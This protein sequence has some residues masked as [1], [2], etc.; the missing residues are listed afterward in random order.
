MRLDPALDELLSQQAQVQLVKGGFG[1]TEGI[2]WVQRGKTGYLVFSDIPANVVNKMTPDGQV[3]VLVKESGYQ[4]PWNGYT[5]MMIGGIFT[6]GLQPGDPNYRQVV[7]VGS[8]GLTFD[9]QGRL[10]LCAYSTRAVQRIEKNGKRV[11]IADRYQGKRFNGPND[12]AV[13][14]DGTIYFSDTYGGMRGRAND[15]SKEIN[16][17]SFYMVRND[18]TSI[19]IQANPDELSGANGLA[20]SPDEKYLYV[21][22]GDKSVWRYEVQADDT[23]AN[24]RQIADL[25]GEQGPGI[26]DGMKVDSKGNL[27]QSGP[28]GI[29]ILSPEG[30]RLGMIRT[31]EVVGNLTFGDP[32]FK[33]LYIAARTSIFKVRLNTPGLPCNS[34]THH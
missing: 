18:I 31:P 2:N 28:G 29:W 23:L 22:N 6:Y 3:S 15:P 33:T 12:V 16:S 19:A 25:K 30:G 10:L 11:T 26:T 24:G 32:D 8:D 34:C 13:K 17:E 9:P 1:V 27:Y 7:L 20:F 4:G 14:K 21:N 5:M